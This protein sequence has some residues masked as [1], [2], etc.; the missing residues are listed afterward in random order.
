[1]EDYVINPISGKPIKKDS[2]IY[3]DLIYRGIVSF[4]LAE[5]HKRKKCVFKLKN[6][7]DVDCKKFPAKKEEE[8]EEAVIIPRK[9]SKSIWMDTI[10]S[11]V[12]RIVNDEREISKI[13][14]LNYVQLRRYIE[15][16]ILKNNVQ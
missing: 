16:I 14:C 7:K 13:Q 6:K 2:R 9:L 12:F 10:T 11:L 3:N 5:D 1:M 15:A 4:N 8:K